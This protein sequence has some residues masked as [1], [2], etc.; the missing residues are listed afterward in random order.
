MLHNTLSQHAA[1]F[2]LCRHR[3]EALESPH[4]GDVLVRYS[5]VVVRGAFGR[6]WRRAL[7][8]GLT[9]CSTLG[10]AANACDDLQLLSQDRANEARW[11]HV[12]SI[13]CPVLLVRGAES[14][15]F[16]RESAEA[17]ARRLGYVCYVEIAGAGHTVQGDNPRDLAAAVTSF[18]AQV[19]D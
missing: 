15:V 3:I 11:G 6:G 17:L 9:S 8:R 4:L 1:E 2:A 19:V 10:L 14:P 5:D 13:P 18:L 16:S 7:E 12:E